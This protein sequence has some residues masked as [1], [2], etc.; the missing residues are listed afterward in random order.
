MLNARA[1]SFSAFVYSPLKVS[2]SVKK[3]GQ[4]KSL[5]LLLNLECREKFCF[6]AKAISDNHCISWAK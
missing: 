6:V 5:K 3:I 4:L 2:F 1:L